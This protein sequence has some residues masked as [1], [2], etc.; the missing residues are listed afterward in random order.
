MVANA[1][2]ADLKKSSVVLTTASGTAV[3]KQ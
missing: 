1:G 2:S 3:I